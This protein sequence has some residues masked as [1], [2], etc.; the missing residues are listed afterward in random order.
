MSYYVLKN[1]KLKK[2][3]SVKI[4]YGIFINLENL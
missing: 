1:A 3:A 4:F 2:E